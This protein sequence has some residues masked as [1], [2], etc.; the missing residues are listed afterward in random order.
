VVLAVKYAARRDRPERIESLLTLL[1][2]L[3]KDHTP[4]VRRNLG[5]FAIG[6]GLLRVDPT[7]TMK[8]LREW[9]RDK[10]QIV[11]W[12][13]AMAFTS[14]IGSFHWPG[15]KS[16]LDRLAR[17]P[18]P[19]VRMA[20]ARAVRRCRELYPEDVEETRR[21][22]LLDRERRETAELVG[23]MRRRSRPSGPL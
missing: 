15:A 23:P 9:S 14:A 7:A 16:I 20:V 1:E 13:V 19:M 3:L 10:D 17:S 21:R 8:C 12:N 6:D 5:A 2:P 11:R 4:Y 22:W 18:E